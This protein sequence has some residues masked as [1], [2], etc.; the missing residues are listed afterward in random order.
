MEEMVSDG[1]QSRLEE[2]L[3]IES[4]GPFWRY[5][6]KRIKAK[7]VRKF[8]YSSPSVF[9]HPEHKLPIRRRQPRCRSCNEVAV[10][11]LTSPLNLKNAGRHYYI[12]PSCPWEDRWVCWEDTTGVSARNPP[13]D[14]D[15]PSRLEV[16]SKRKGPK[17]GRGFWACVTGKC[18]YYSENEDG[19]PGVS[20]DV[21]FYP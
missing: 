11:K 10:R 19:T 1:E 9:A 21:G 3:T 2:L 5:Q 15:E 7:P 14:C 13:C 20:E 12:C 6:T 8:P 16:I 17:A 4:P 18:R